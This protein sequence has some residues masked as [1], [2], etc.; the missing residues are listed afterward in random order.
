M[1]KH[2]D[3]PSRIYLLDAHPVVRLGLA[4]LISKESK[5]K[6]AGESDNAGGC[7]E[8]LAHQAPDLLIMGLNLPGVNGLE[9]IKKLRTQFPSL[10]ILVLSIY[11]ESLYAQRCLRAGARGF[12][13]KREGAAIL[14]EG[15]RKVLKGHIF[16]GSA[17]SEILLA[18]PGSSGGTWSC[19]L[20]LLSN[21][22]LEVFRLVGKGLRTTQI[23]RTLGLSHKTIESYREKIKVKLNLSH[24][25]ELLQSAIQFDRFEENH[26]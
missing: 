12:I 4:H 13:P 2:S 19:S 24:A 26:F 17:V 11:E 6:I 8:D 23:G 15:I 1:S 18:K 14:L 3:H 7:L 9:F 22:E 21:R 25:S 20:D 10:P 16:V 5:L